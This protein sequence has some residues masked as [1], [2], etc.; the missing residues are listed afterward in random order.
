MRLAVAPAIQDALTEQRHADID[1]IA[2]VSEF[3]RW[4]SGPVTR[5]CGHGYHEGHESVSCEGFVRTLL[6]DTPCLCPCHATSAIMT[7]AA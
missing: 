7:R 3:A 5:F 4:L 1:R 6:I 2:G